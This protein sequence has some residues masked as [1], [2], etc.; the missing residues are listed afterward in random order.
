MRL[1]LKTDIIKLF[2]ILIMV[3]LVYLFRGWD[4]DKGYLYLHIIFTFDLL[5]YISG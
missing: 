3:I 4:S 2:D 5:G 1:K